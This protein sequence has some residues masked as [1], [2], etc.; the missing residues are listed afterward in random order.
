MHGL[1]IWNVKETEGRKKEPK[2]GCHR[3]PESRQEVYSISDAAAAAAEE[4][5]KLQEMRRRG[6]E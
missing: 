3:A 4:E 6:G 1:H 5:K 2:K